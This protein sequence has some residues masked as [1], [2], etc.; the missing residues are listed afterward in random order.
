MILKGGLEMVRDRGF[1]ALT[2]GSLAA[3]LSISYN[4]VTRI[5]RN[6]IVLGKAI[7]RY[8]LDTGDRDIVRISKRIGYL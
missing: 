3:R 8:A 2:C 7:A 4:T 6:R 1:D 5:F